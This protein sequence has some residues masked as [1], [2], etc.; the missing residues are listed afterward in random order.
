[1]DQSYPE[2]GRFFLSK[3][4]NEI[5]STELTYHAL[6]AINLYNDNTQ[7]V[8]VLGLKKRALIDY[9]MTKTISASHSENLKQAVVSIKA[10]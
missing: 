3:K 4:P 7:E 6:R 10:A 8:K 5:D 2:N 1:M 9:F